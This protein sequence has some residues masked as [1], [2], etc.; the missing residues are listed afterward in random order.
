MFNVWNTTTRLPGNNHYS[1]MRFLRSYYFFIQ[2]SL[3]HKELS[4]SPGHTVIQLSMWVTQ[5][6]ISFKNKSTGSLAYVARHHHRFPKKIFAIL[7]LTVSI[8]SLNSLYQSMWC[9]S[10]SYLHL[11]D[12]TSVYIDISSLLLPFLTYH[13]RSFII[14]CIRYA[15]SQIKDQATESDSRDARKRLYSGRARCVQFAP[16]S[17]CLLRSVLTSKSNS[18]LPLCLSDTEFTTVRTCSTLVPQLS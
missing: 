12:E 17:V 7:S 14:S 18:P 15:L 1:V 9:Y 6:Q 4:C 3:L 11:I 10:A 16:W 8:C 13:T 2:Y 5:L